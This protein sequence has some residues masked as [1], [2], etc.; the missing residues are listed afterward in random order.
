MDNREKCKCHGACCQTILNED[1]FYCEDERK[2]FI[3]STEAKWDYYSLPQYK[4]P[5]G[6]GLLLAV[7]LA[8][9]ILLIASGCSSSR[10]VSDVHQCE[11]LPAEQYFEC[12]D[13]FEKLE[14]EKDS[15]K[16]SRFDKP[17]PNF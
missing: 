1:K 11:L 5:R 14:S 3:E 16:R 15:L 8:S 9:I 7:M 12:L 13:Y 10:Y 6:L 4:R 2:E 17:F